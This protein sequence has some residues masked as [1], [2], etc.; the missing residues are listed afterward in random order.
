MRPPCIKHS[1]AL[2][3][4]RAIRYPDPGEMVTVITSREFRVEEIIVVAGG[5]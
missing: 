3:N 1:S 2:S 5:G 4:R